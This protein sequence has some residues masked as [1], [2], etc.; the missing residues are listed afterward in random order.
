MKFPDLRNRLTRPVGK[1]VYFD[2]KGDRPTH[3]W[4]STPIRLYVSPRK[5]ART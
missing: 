5:V 4:R 1:V 2:D 3:T